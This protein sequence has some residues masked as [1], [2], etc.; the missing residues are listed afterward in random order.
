MIS[1]LSDRGAIPR[2]STNQVDLY[3]PTEVVFFILEYINKRKQPPASSGCFTCGVFGFVVYFWPLY[4]FFIQK[5][6]L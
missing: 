2:S 5:L 4:K 3:H 6:P 1:Y